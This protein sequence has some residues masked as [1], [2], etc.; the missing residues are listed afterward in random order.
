MTGC[1]SIAL[2]DVDLLCNGTRH[3]NLALMKISSY[4]KTK[5]NSKLLYKKEQLADLKKYDG[6]I[7]SKVFTFSIDPPEIVDLFKKTKKS[8]RELNQCIVDFFNS[9]SDGKNSINVAIG[10]TGYFKD[11]GRN[12]HHSIEHIFPD[13]TLYDDYVQEMITNGRK[14]VYFNDYLNY[15]IGFTSRGCFRK[16][17][18]CVN[19]KY[20]HCSF[21]AHVSEFVDPD[22]PGIYLWDDN[23]FACKDWEMIFNELKE[24]GKPFQ[25][26]QGL[27]I[28]LLSEKKA[29][30]VS[31]S[32]YKGDVIFAFDHVDDYALM[33]KKLG[34][35]RK[36]SKKPTKMYVLCAFDSWEYTP[37]QYKTIDPDK[38]HLTRIYSAN[39]QDERDLIDIEGVFYRISLLMKYG[40]LPYIMRYEK[41]KE[42]K[43]RGVYI[44]LARWCNQP[45]FYKK[46]S[47]REFCLANQAY[48][49]TNRK[50]APM[51]AL[52]TLENDANDNI[53]KYLDM[54]YVDLCQL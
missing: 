41:Y 45:Q 48:A 42:S 46:M 1:P 36:H 30:A 25:F 49:K 9:M 38:K 5:S 22:R 34:L 24:T 7:I 21:H 18:F 8:K 26:R 47:F 4:S 43:Y 53:K 6:I 14:P 17:D 33:D 50:C 32:R 29:I 10:G 54:K 31:K 27:D 39:T 35:W 28:R 37:L 52:E 13:Y 44:Q 15:S 19:K 3:P 20:D 12:L 11:G 23:V 40:C 16:C 51:V 2:I